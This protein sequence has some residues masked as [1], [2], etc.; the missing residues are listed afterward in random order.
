M[1]C[2]AEAKRCRNRSMLK[3]A[4]SV[5]MMQDKRQ[6][7]LLIRFKCSDAA[8]NVGYGNIGL[9]RADGTASSD[10]VSTTM[11]G[12]MELC[13]PGHGCPNRKAD[14]SMPTCDKELLHHLVSHIIM[15]YADA[16]GDEQAA[17]NM[18]TYDGSGGALL[19]SHSLVGR[20]KPMQR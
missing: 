5:T 2:I 3:S 18:L 8:L 13:T 12:L 10:V 19:P 1:W 11:S 20:D 16:A 7:Y 14:G 9:F 6:D 17:S 4:V 15:F